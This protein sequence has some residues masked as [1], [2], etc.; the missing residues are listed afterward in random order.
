MSEQQSE[1]MTI[2]AT[3]TDSI[4]SGAWGQPIS[5]KQQARLQHMLDAWQAQTDHGDRKGP[6]DEVPLTGADVSWLAERSGRDAYGR[7]PNLHLEG[8]NLG[9]AHLE[10][11]LLEYAHLESAYLGEAHL[12]GALLNGARLQSTFLGKAHLEGKVMEGETLGPADLRL[13]FLDE[14]TTLNDI[15]LGN[16]QHGYVR[17][18]DVRWGGVNLAVV[19]LPPAHL[20]GDEHEAYTTKGDNQTDAYQAAV[21]ANRQLTVAL[22]GLGLNEEAAR[23]A[24]RAQVLQRRVFRRQRKVGAYLFSLLIAA[25]AGYGYRLGRILIGYALI[26]SVFAAGYFFTGHTLSSPALTGQ[27]LL[28]GVLDAFQISLNAIHGRVFFAQFGLYTAQSWLATAESIFGI[29]IEGVFVAMLIQRFF[30]R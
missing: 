11:A 24:Y 2:T 19:H 20:L 21:R 30:G 7:V 8:A 3:A 1:P 9:E 26:V 15:T 13:A 10:R 18:A 22:Q 27:S 5:E 14:A 17:L 29:V 28:Q 4:P 25:L 16:A 12:E 6:F 23:F